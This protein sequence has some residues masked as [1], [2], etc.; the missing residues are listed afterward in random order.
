VYGG[1]WQRNFKGATVD[2]GERWD[3]WTAYLKPA[4][5]KYPVSTQPSL[6]LCDVCVWRDEVSL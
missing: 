1:P 3:V 4:V 6:S 2:T 5:A